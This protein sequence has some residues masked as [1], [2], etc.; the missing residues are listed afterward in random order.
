MS[1]YARMAEARIRAAVGRRQR[2]TYRRGAVSGSPRRSAKPPPPPGH[3]SSAKARSF[4]PSQP[5]L[6]LD[7]GEDD[8]GGVE[9]APSDLDLPRRK[10]ST[11]TP[12]LGAVPMSDPLQDAPTL[13]SGAS[14]VVQR[15]EPFSGGTQ[16]APLDDL[17]SGGTKVAPLDDLLSGGTKVA[18]AP[19]PTPAP[20][21]AAVVP[22]SALPRASTPFVVAG[23]L[24]M[25]AWGAAAAAGVASDPEPLPKLETAQP[26]SPNVIASPA[27][28]GP[29]PTSSDAAVAAA[30][31]GGEESDEAAPGDKAPPAP[32]SAATWSLTAA[33]APRTLKLSEGMTIASFRGSVVGYGGADGGAQAWTYEGE[34][35]GIFPLQGGAL[36]IP[37]TQKVIVVSAADGTERFSAELP[38]STP[39]IVAADADA[40]HVLLALS[41]ARFVLLT[42]AACGDTPDEGAGECMREVGRLRGEYL[43][44]SCTV[45][46]GDDRKYYL[47]ED[48][49]LRAFDAELQ[50]VFE[51]SMPADIRSLVRIPGGRLSLQFAQEAALLDTKS[52]RGSQEVRLRTSDTDGPAGCVLWRYGR[53]VDPVPPAPVDAD[54]VALN[55][56]GK[57]QVVRAGDDA[58]KVPLDTFGPVA[59]ASGTLFTVAAEG[60]ELFVAEVDATNG[61]V[62][63]MHPLP[64]SATSEDRA[65]THVAWEPG[66]VA[67][68]VGP[69]IGVLELPE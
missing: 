27:K 60:E 23:V 41:S 11:R 17:L 36:A 50:L 49:A 55:E 65:T 25:M 43:E 28:P 66:R 29:A 68:S 6:R 8:S 34:H 56:R 46:L 22:G 32:S 18:P 5:L 39:E 67:V 53:E 9:T 20:L 2:A 1:P 19:I 44:E 7:D 42:V 13:V 37:L 3:E 51:A 4:D 59:V 26:P 58:W 38:G 69:N 10:D 12:G 16:V 61:S 21:P 30:A 52:C 62:D 63:A 64:F 15:D 48:D 31:A 24:A 35:E 54:S 57:L 47:A 33:A 14:A 45:A 40:G